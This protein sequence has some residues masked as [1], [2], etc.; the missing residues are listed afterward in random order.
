[1]LEQ[2]STSTRENA[3]YLRALLPD[4]KRV[5]VVTDDFHVVRARRVF[6]ES[7]GA[8]DG[9]GAPTPPFFGLRASLIEV[10]KLLRDLVSG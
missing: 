1:M 9:I 7:F 8:A 10:P 6:A 2:K 4:A 3:E 5:L